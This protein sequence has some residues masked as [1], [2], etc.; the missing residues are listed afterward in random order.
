MKSLLTNAP[1]LVF[2]N[3]KKE[4]VLETDASGLGLRAVL[5][6]QQGNGGVAPIAYG[7]HTLQPH[8]K[9]YGVTELEALG[10]VWAV[11]HFHPYLYGHRCNALTGHEALKSLLNTPHSSGKLAR[12]GLPILELD[13]QIHYCPG[14][15]NQAADILSCLP[16]L[17]LLSVNQR[18]TILAEVITPPIFQVKDRE[19]RVNHVNMISSN[20]ID[21]MAEYQDADTDLKVLK[22]YLLH[23]EL[24]REEKKA[25]EFVLGRSQ[26]EVID[27]F[28]YNVERDKT[29]RVIHPTSYRKMLFE[30]AHRGQFGAHLE[31]AKVHGQLARSYWWSTM[32]TN[33]IHWSHL[34][35]ICASKHVG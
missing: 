28:L 25:R 14:R 15:V 32:R 1:L 19:A 2:P 11:K 12:R 8:K 5:G 10:V 29:L 31:S 27:G 34:F 9:K 23:G 35:T 13:L 24:P 16:L 21:M 6:Q 7:S 4:F 26:F 17:T 3:F 20:A 33:I 18:G 30:Q 22:S